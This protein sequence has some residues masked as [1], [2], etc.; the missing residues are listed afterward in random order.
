MVNL[1]KIMKFPELFC[2]CENLPSLPTPNHMEEL[3]DNRE[4]R[5]PGLLEPTD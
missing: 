4:H 2:S 1:K 5:A 3:L